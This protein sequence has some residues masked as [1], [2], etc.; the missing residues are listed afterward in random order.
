MHLHVRN[1]ILTKFLLPQPADA[2]RKPSA[3]LFQIR[4]KAYSVSSAAVQGQLMINTGCVQCI[5][6]H[7]TVFDRN[8]SVTT[9]MPDKSRWKIRRSFFFCG[10]CIAE[11]FLF[12][13]I[14]TEEIQPAVPVC[15]GFDKGD[16]RITQDQCIRSARFPG[17]LPTFPLF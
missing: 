11:L 13:I 7:E 14:R 8:R 15:K 10:I 1:L 17:K 5:R 6:K 9:A 2:V 16:D 4:C 12:R 3:D